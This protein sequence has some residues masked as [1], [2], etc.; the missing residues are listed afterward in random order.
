MPTRDIIVIGA[1]AGGVEALREVVRALPGDFPGSVFVVLHLAE[2]IPSVL[3][4][5][6]GRTSR[7]ACAPARDG[8]PIVPGR[9]YV[10]PPDYHVLVK[11]GRVEV[12]RGPRENGHRPA[13]DPLFRSAARAYGPRVVGVILTGSLDDGTLGLREVRRRGGTAVVQ[14]PDEALFPGMP[15]SALDHV[16][17]DHVVPLRV[18]PELL[19]RLATTELPEEPGT[20]AA[21]RTAQDREMDDV[22]DDVE[23]ERDITEI[24]GGERENESLGGVPSSYTC[25]ECHGAL[26]EL[27]EGRLVRYRCRVGHSY[28]E[29]TLIDHKFTSLEAALWTALTALEES[30]SLAQRMAERAAKTGQPLGAAKFRQRAEQFETR[31][32]VVRE[33]LDRMPT[34]DVADVS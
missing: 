20:E 17:A 6:L 22:E 7:L 30:A 9:V 27:I 3:P 31:A 14:N 16:G 13:V 32:R 28:S 18:I 24:A 2:G 5:I 34:H 11:P 25:P 4:R 1:S 29:P 26:W 12:L 15:R 33:V 21:A 23:S 8:E 10:A 19:V